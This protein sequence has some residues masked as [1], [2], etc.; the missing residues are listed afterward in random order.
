[1][2]PPG[3]PDRGDPALERDRANAAR[4]ARTVEPTPAPRRQ[5]QQARSQA[6][7]DSLLDAADSIVVDA[8]VDGLTTTLVAARAGV[9]VG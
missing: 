5:P 6:K 4:T 1:M 7:V 9:A 3:S 2:S 8:G